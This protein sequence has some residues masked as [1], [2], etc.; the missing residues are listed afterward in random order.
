MNLTETVKDRIQSIFRDVS[1]AVPEDNKL[2]VSVRKDQMLAILNFL[3]YEGYDYLI[4]VSCVDWIDQNELELVY[5]ISSYMKTPEEYTDEQKLNII[6]K[7]TVPRESPEIKT[8][9]TIFANAEPYEREIHELFGVN[10]EGH[11]RLTP[12]FLSMEYDVPPFRKDFDT[13]KY[14]EEVFDAIPFPP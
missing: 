10:F 12:L 9:T 8:A 14:V 11:P 2:I 5:V 4:L 6:L 1:I 7:T 3:K 13:R